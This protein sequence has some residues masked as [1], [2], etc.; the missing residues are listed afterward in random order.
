MLDIDDFKAVNDTYGHQQG[1]LV[2]SRSRGSCVR[3]REIDEPARYGGEEMAVILPG[4]DLEG[5]VQLRRA[6]A[7]G[8]RGLCEHPAAV[9]G[10]A[11]DVTLSV[12][13]AALPGLRE[14]PEG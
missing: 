10:D 11:L 9:G 2:L 3:S 7:G 8:D 12:G 1:D 4:T 14:T 6:H 13:V 5:A